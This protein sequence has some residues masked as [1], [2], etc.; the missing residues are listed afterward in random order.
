MFVQNEFPAEKVFTPQGDYSHLQC[1]KPC[2]PELFP[3]RTFIDAALPHIDIHDTHEITKP[4]LVP[5]C[6]NCGGPVFMNVRGGSWFLES[7]HA[8][9]RTKYLSF[10]NKALTDAR[11]NRK[12][13]A[14]LEIG[15]GFNTPSVIR[16]PNES[17][18]QTYPDVV[19]LIRLNN[20]RPEFQKGGID[21]VNAVGIPL[22]ATPAVR[23][24][25]RGLGL[26]D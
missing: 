3:T 22:D 20:D 14:I 6:K 23:F 9:Q 2:K 21:G 1:L 19:R 4:E 7:P 12:T 13:V 15:V 10:I 24:L 25:S 17:L 8:T 16:W 18:A 11:T 5:K 26:S